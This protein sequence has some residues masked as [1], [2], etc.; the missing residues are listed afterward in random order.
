[1]LRQRLKGPALAAYYP[2]KSATVEDIQ[3]EFARF[4]LVTWNEEE[5]DRLEGLQIAKL[6]GKGAPKKKRTADGE[7]VPSLRRMAWAAK[8]GLD[9]I[10]HGLLTTVVNS[11]QERQE[12]KEVIS[13]D[14]GSACCKC[15]Y[16]HCRR[17]R[18]RILENC[19]FDGNYYI[20]HNLVCLCESC[21]VKCVYNCNS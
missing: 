9:Q 2:R 12:E 21:C 5:E 14:C 18:L 3:K 7:F 20:V 19:V 4:D 6:R 1:V 17:F 13:R 15:T 11:E 8:Q 10:R 16:T